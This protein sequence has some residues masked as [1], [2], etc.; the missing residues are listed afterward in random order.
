M[1]PDPC[2]SCGA[3]MAGDQRYCLECGQ[4]RGDPRVDYQRMLRPTPVASPPEPP[5]GVA[6]VVA[7]ARGAWTLPAALAT[8]ACLLLAMGIGVLI[9]R[10]GDDGASQAAA[11]AP[12]VIRVSSE[13]APAATSTDAAPAP[14]A[15]THTTAAK[16][17]T[18]K[19]AAATTAKASAQTKTLE[20]SS[21]DDYVKQS[22]KLPKQVGTGGKAPPKDKKPAAG[23]GG[24]EEIG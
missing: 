7:R 10:S 24:F 16:R 1:T 8:I 3:P 4:R 13:Q 9:G 11:P 18:A 19:K 5:G 15:G 12:Q 20:K 2:L 23:G 17:K 6:G 14:A 22:A 21:G